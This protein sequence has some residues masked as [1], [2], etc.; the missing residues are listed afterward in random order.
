MT[1]I[2]AILTAIALICSTALVI[3][4]ST[5]SVKRGRMWLFL[6]ILFMLWVVAKWTH[7]LVS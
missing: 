4:L 3:R 6:T 2:E 7:V 5:A 1:Q